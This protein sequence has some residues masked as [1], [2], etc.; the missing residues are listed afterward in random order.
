MTAPIIQADQINKLY[1]SYRALHDISLQVAAGEFIALVGPSGC[2]KTSLLKIIAGFENPSSG[3]LHIAGAD[4]AGIPPSQRP[5]RMVFQKLAL[6]PHKTV[7]E[8]IAFSLKIAGRPQTEIDRK[9]RE[10][11]G[12][13][14]LKDIYINRHPHELSGGEQQRVALARAMVS[15]PHVLLLDEPLSALD[16]KLKKSLQA[17]LKHL[18][19]NFGT[20]FV[21]VTHD[22]EE[23]MMLADRICV[24]RA[25]EI[26][27]LGVPT[28]IYY[29]PA[30]AFV[31]GFIGD[32]NLL[33]ATLHRADGGLQVTCSSL[34]ATPGLLAATQ[35]ASAAADGE[36][37]LMIRPELLRVLAP[38]EAAECLIEGVV[39]EYF[40]KGA[41][42]QYRITAARSAAPI[43]V[44]V[45]GTAR[46]PAAVKD[47]VRLGFAASD[48][49]MVGA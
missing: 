49:F 34:A 43:V 38:D 45:P 19:R 28:D 4:M 32:T 2:G 12:L 22:L 48:I 25:G 9:V 5:T 13:M 41:S 27:Q 24:M 40:I 10:M 44:E 29:R 35:A 15:D 31:A 11:M 8:N 33:P 37:A 42:I 36:A 14:H 21:H 39:D 23:A 16:A 6:F 1:G 26:L 7:G 18:H 17:E 46:L 47:P 3:S 20:S 30:N